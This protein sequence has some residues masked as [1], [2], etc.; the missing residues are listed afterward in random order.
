[1]SLRSTEEVQMLFPDILP[2][3]GSNEL[4]PFDAPLYEI[5]NG[6]RQELPPM[7]AYET[8]IASELLSYVRPF[9]RDRSLGLA[10]T[11]MLFIL[12][13]DPELRRRPD[14]AFVSCQRWPDRQPVPR[15]NAWDVVP[16]LA[17]EAISQTNTADDIPLRVRE[18]FAAGVE[19]VWI[20][21]PAESLVYVYESPL[22]VRVLTR[23][24]QI[25]GG[26]V[27]PGF[28]LRLELILKEAPEDEPRLE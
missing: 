24:D 5:V 7:G 11:E 18:Y 1:M 19:L 16:N 12:R 17:V 14:M 26:N 9:A 22:H 8:F 10:V 25:D 20:I 3:T 4:E 15:T 6:Q 13:R 23:N 21:F 28:Q 27:L 2:E